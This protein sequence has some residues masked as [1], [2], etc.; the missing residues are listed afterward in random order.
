MPK[1]KNN[2]INKRAS[3]LKFRLDEGNGKCI[4]LIGVRDNG[5]NEGIEIEKLCHS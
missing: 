2:K 1:I 4:Y 5:E 3:Q